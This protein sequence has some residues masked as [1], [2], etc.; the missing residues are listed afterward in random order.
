MKKELA[1]IHQ[2]LEA[3]EELVE[4]MRK[5]LNELRERAGIPD[6]SETEESPSPT[7]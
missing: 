3:L 7:E 2:R 1:D 5:V 6:P 4:V